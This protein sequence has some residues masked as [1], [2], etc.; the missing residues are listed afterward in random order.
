M[1]RILSLALCILTYLSTVHPFV[2]ISPSAATTKPQDR[3][4][5]VCCPR[6]AGGVGNRFCLDLVDIKSSFH[7]T[8][9][10]SLFMGRSPD[11]IDTYGDWSSYVDDS[12]KVVYYFNAKTGGEMWFSVGLGVYVVCV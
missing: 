9:S 7:K 8:Y 5:C 10:F 3:S 11:A 12:T 6:H 1:M 2:V 4:G